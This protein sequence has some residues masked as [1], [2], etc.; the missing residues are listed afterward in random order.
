MDLPAEYVESDPWDGQAT[1]DS[2][3]PNVDP[4]TISWAGEFLLSPLAFFVS[5]PCATAEFSENNASVSLLYDVLEDTPDQEWMVLETILIRIATRYTP[6]GRFPVYKN[7]ST[8]SGYRTTV[9]YDAAVCALKYEPWVIEAY[10]T[11]TG[12]PSALRV[13]GKGSNGVPLSP[14]GKM[15]GDQIAKATYLNTTGKDMVFNSA[16]GNGIYQIAKTEGVS[17]WYPTPA[18]SH[19]VFPPTNFL[20][21]STHSTGRFF[22]RWRWTRG[23]YRTLCGPARCHPRTVRCGLHSTILCRVR[24]HRRAFVRG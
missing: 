19:I 10:N 21:T 5:N 2:I 11:S 23:I 1:N 4:S 16:R 13:V 6:S 12:L 9:G 3:P 20:L 15:R 8:P 18:V 7:V 22:H 17:D 14:S 24:T